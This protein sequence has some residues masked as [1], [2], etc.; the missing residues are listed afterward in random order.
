[1]WQEAPAPHPQPAL[2]SGVAREARRR[3]LLSSSHPAHCHLR[4]WPD[5]SPDTPFLPTEWSSLLWVAAEG[6]QGQG[7]ASSTHHG[8]NQTHFC[9]CF[10]TTLPLFMLLP[11]SSVLVFSSLPGCPPPPGLFHLS[12]P[13]SFLFFLPLPGL[14]SVPI[15]PSLCPPPPHMCHCLCIINYLSLSRPLCSVSSHA[16]L[17]PSLPCLSHFAPSCFSLSFFFSLLTALS[18]CLSPSISL[19]LS[20]PLSVPPP[21]A[22]QSLLIPGKSA[23]RFGRRGSAIGIGTVEE[24]VVHRAT[25]SGGCCTRSSPLTLGT[26]A[27]LGTWPPFLSTGPRACRTE[28]QHLSAPALG[29][30]TWARTN[31]PCQR[32][33]TLPGPCQDPEPK[34]PPAQM[35]VPQ[36]RWFCMKHHPSLCPDPFPP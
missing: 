11:L 23:S 35:H 6:P 30:G 28:C 14:I 25:G 18:L 31:G 10:C 7:Q 17:L 29:P 12:I 34:D 26:E 4:S 32:L 36:Y 5:L 2:C 9:F 21:A 22:C 20:S 3:P 27:I 33:L 1:M 24:V 16:S 8:S 15:Q 19:S 13:S